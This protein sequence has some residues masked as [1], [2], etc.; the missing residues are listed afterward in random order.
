[1]TTAADILAQ[2]ATLT[3]AERA[4]FFHQLAGE[5]SFPIAVRA[6]AAEAWQSYRVTAEQ[7]TVDMVLALD[8]PEQQVRVTAVRRNEHGRIDIAALNTRTASPVVLEDVNP[9]LYY[10]RVA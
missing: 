1:M 10:T 4:E 5:P 7:V 6:A 3:N 9:T 2:F 8:S